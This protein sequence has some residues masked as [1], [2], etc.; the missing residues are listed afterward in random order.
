ME[1]KVAVIGAGY[2]GKKHV[3]EF[4]RLKS[5]KLVA[6]AD[7]VQKNLDY[8]REKYGI[9]D[10]STD[11]R[12]ILAN[13]EVDAVSICVNNNMHYQ[14]AKDAL[15]AGKHVLVEKPLTM[16]VETSKE[17]IALSQKQGKVLCV[18]HLFRFNNA[19]L[20]LKELN[21]KGEFGRIFFI[22][23]QW[24]NNSPLIGNTDVIFD[25]APH[26]IDICNFIT[27]MWPTKSRYFG[28]P[29]RR[30]ELDEVAFVRSEH[31]NGFVH[32]IELSWLVAEKKRE[33]FVAG[34][35]MSA[36]ADCN[37]QKLWVYTPKT[38]GS[39]CKE[40]GITQNNALEAELEA[41]VSDCKSNNTSASTNT[42]EVG[43]KV[44]ENIV[45]CRKYSETP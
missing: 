40:I 45:N 11:Y 19:V 33:V 37:S 20:K 39:E 30:G 42:G 24:T 44:I 43:L 16:D 41:F 34:E 32:Y 18:G 6:V 8:C 28:D 29:F 15:L 22:K 10:T 5:A 3:D 7:V 9:T 38:L 13:P 17:L 25:L 4:S 36:K 35:K 26:A 2:W 14:V 27:G 23:T 1:L 31:E 12:Q 21:Q